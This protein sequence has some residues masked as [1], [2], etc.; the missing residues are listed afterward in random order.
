MT[1]Q[2]KINGTGLA[3]ILRAM[4]CSKAGIIAAFRNEAAFRQEVFLCALLVPLALWLGQSNV[5][6]ALL[7]GSVL[8]VL[9][10]ELLNTAIEVVVNRISADRHA[11]S[12]LAKDLGS[13]AVSM[14]ILLTVAVWGL[15]L[16]T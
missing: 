5:E 10:V 15:V 2:Q 4:T 14:A 3:R 16:F 9:I 1:E 13:A 8:L 12:G 6:R 11:L 7:A